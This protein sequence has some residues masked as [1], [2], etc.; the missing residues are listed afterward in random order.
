MAAKPDSTMEVMRRRNA[1]RHEETYMSFGTGIYSLDR[2]VSGTGLL[3]NFKNASLPPL[4]FRYEYAI[5]DYVGV[6][7]TMFF[8]LAAYKWNKSVMVYNY[9]TYTYEP[10][11]YPEKYS[12][13]SLGFLGRLNIHFAGDRTNDAYFG[14]GMGYE[15]YMLK[16]T[17]D[18]PLAQDRVPGRLLP[19]ATEVVFGYRNYVGDNTALYVEAGWAKMLVNFG[20]TVWLDR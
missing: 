4:F 7:G 12:G 13:A 9:D 17:T 14:F 8:Q 18:D 11:I 5:S 6:G 20:I 19:F 3:S 10:T 16:M 15:F 2:P 1:F